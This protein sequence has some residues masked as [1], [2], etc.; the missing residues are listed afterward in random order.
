MIRAWT[1]AAALMVSTT[2][3]ADGPMGVGSLQ[4]GMTKAEVEALTEGAV[5]LAA[6]LAPDADGTKLPDG[7]ERFDMS[8]QTPWSETPLD[9][10]VTFTNGA[11]SEVFI[12]LDESEARMKR[13][14]QQISEKF[15]AG[16]YDDSRRK[17]Y[18]R[19]Y[20][21]GSEEVLSG[22]VTHS[23]VKIAGGSEITTRLTSMTMDSCLK[24]ERGD[25]A[26]YFVSM[27]V[28]V[29]AAAQNPF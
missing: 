6:P 29:K 3:M 17:E 5:R 25:G 16:D 23:W 19:T 20:G 11:A 28:S 24:R 12:N 2:A 8:L 10:G 27:S 21:G 14:G 18:C 1:A 15:G 13:I 26:S 4:I 7:M 9:G 22:F